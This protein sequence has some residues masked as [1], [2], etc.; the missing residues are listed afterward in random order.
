MELLA[1]FTCES[2][3][4]CLLERLTWHQCKY[5]YISE[6]GDTKN[7]EKNDLINLKSQR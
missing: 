5:R 6:E 7:R 1:D 3:H 2:Y 4:I